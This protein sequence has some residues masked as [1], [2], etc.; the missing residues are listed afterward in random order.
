MATADI[1]SAGH[2]GGKVATTPRITWEP[3]PRVR[4][5]TR[6][7]AEVGHVRQRLADVLAEVRCLLGVETSRRLTAGEAMLASRL[8]RES[9]ALRLELAQLRR[10]FEALRAEKQR[11][12][13]TANRGGRRH[14][15]GR[16]ARG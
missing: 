8:L 9:E 11:P 10:E 12:G 4:Q 7:N 5:L 13:E 6:L 16:P 2:A 15:A 1:T 14:S 3:D